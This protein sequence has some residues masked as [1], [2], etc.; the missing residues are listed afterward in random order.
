MGVENRQLI[1]AALIF[2]AI[3]MR[4][5]ASARFKAVDRNTF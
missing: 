5:M 3:V 1:A 2:T 4:A